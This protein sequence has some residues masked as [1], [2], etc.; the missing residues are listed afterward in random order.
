MYLRSNKNV[1]FFEREQERA[2]LRAAHEVVPFVL[3]VRGVAL[4]A[5]RL[6]R[7]G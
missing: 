2:V 6:F 5:Q 4:D 7:V 1:P 3:T